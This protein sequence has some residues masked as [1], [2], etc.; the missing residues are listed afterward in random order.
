MRE[1][2]IRRGDYNIETSKIW[3]RWGGIDGN[4]KIY[5]WDACIRSA[6]CPWMIAEL[7]SGFRYRYFANRWAKR[8]VRD[9]G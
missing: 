2:T 1:K 6:H 3:E 9:H 7:K 5:R 8:W 4:G